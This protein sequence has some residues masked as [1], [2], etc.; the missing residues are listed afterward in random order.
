M[1]I[2]YPTYM[3]IYSRRKRF[4]A[5]VVSLILFA[6]TFLITLPII[7]KSTIGLYV[8]GVLYEA[9][10]G[11]LITIVLTLFKKRERYSSLRLVFIR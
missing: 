3:S 2:L 8:R 1:P 9:L 11:F 7:F 6:T 4:I 5:L 10:P